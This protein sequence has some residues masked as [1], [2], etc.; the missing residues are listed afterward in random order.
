MNFDFENSEKYLA[1]S[2]SPEAAE[3]VAKLEAL[4]DIK[5]LSPREAKFVE[6]IKARVL[7]EKPISEKQK[8]WLAKIIHKCK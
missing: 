2:V 1:K 3:K 6:D 5:K 8:I 7:I 4:I